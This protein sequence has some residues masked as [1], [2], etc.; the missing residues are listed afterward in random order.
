MPIVEK[1]K[2][3]VSILRDLKSKL[4]PKQAEERKW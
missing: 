4:N 3:L 2:G 1:K